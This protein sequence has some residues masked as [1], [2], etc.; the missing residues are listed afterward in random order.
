MA[1]GAGAEFSMETVGGRR[2]RV[3]RWRWDQLDDRPPLL[4]FNGMGANIEAIVPFAEALGDRPFI[5]Y[6]MPGIGGSPEPVVP[7]N[8]AMVAWQ[9]SALLRR[10]GCAEVDVMGLS[11]GG[12]MAQHFAL[13]HPKAVRRLVLVATSAGM[14]MVPGTQTTLARMAEP[15]TLAGAARMTEHFLSLYGALVGK[16]SDHLARLKAPTARG[17]IYQ[18]LAIGGW[19]SAPLLPLVDHPTLILMGDDDEIVPLANGHILHSLIPKSR[20]EIIAGGGH[21]FIL[22]HPD[23][24][25]KRVREF[26]DAPDTPGRKAA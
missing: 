13:Q 11:W 26:L 6:D 17:Y 16:A 7:Y 8:A 18:L 2:L 12:G 19:T 3:A 1:E 15:C 9:T 23:E 5:T 24:T 10:F 25:L 4:F 21:L 22:S 20:L 14:T